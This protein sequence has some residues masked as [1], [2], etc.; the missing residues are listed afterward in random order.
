MAEQNEQ[1]LQW[2]TPPPALH[3]LQEEV[4]VWRVSLAQSD[5]SL[6]ARF[7]C[8]S[9]EEQQRARRF[10][11][12]RDQRRYIISQSSLRQLIGWYVQL[13]PREVQ[14]QHGQRGK[15]I[16]L[17]EQHVPYRLTFNLSHSHEMAVYAFARNREIGVDIEHIR[18]V[19]DRDQ[20]VKRFFAPAEQTSFFELPE[21]LRTAAFF[22]CWTC[23][24]AFI[25]AL[26]D[27][28]YYP[29]DQFVVAFAPGET[30]RLLS[31]A[32]HPEALTQWSLRAFAPAPDYT[33]AIV[34]EGQ[35]WSLHCW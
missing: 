5:A 19:P 26:G 34:A 18:P 33:A 28:L 29:L 12:E 17:P 8:L 14:F 23:K 10:H 35:G 1:Q 22:Q 9:S 2:E 6:A 20:I 7:A 15:P 24:E 27:G 30:A 3:L 21:T 4:H 11:F 31:V 32:D 13:A 25:K 16:L